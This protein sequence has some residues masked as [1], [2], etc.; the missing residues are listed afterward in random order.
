MVTSEALFAH[1][2]SAADEAEPEQE[3]AEGVFFVP[4]RFI[5]QFCS[6]AFSGRQQASQ[7]AAFIP[8]AGISP[9]HGRRILP[10]VSLTSRRFARGAHGTAAGRA[11]LRFLLA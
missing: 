11:A 5:L 9:T 10:S 6:L 4:D 8:T 3:T 7:P 1:P 2:V